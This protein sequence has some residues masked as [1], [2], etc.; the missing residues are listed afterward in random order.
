MIRAANLALRRGATELFRDA[1][2]QIQQGERVG[3]IGNNGCGKSSLFALLMGELSADTGELNVPA[4]WCIAIMQQE[5]PH[6]RRNAVEYVIDGDTELRELEAKL[7]QAQK[8]G[9]DH[10]AADLLGELDTIQAYNA[11]TRANQLLTG[12]GFKTAHL[13]REVS[14]FSG[15]WRVRLNLARALMRRSNLLLL[16]E[17]TN[18]LDVDAVAWLESW[19]L[20]YPGTLLLISHDRDF[21][22]NITQRTLRFEQGC[23]QVYQG[24]YSAAEKQQA[25]RL[26]QQQALYKKQQAR[27]RQIDQFVSRFR[28]KAS[29][30]KQAQSRLKELDRLEII[31]AAHLESPFSFTLPCRE[32]Q[33]DPLLDLRQ[34]DLGYDQTP[35]L[36]GV[37]VS[38]RPGDRIG[39]LG[40]NGAGKT[41]LLKSIAGQI[42]LLSG[43]RTPG[44]YLRIGYFAQQQLEALDL[45]ASPSLQ[46]QRLT[47]QAKE[48][49]IRNFLGGFGFGEQATADSIE[50]FSGGEKA[51]LALAIIAWQQPNLLILDE[52]TNH[53]DMQMRHAL[54]MA[55]QEY[56]GAVLLVSHDRHLLR[57][58]VDEL[59]LVNHGEVNLFDGSLEDYQRQLR[60]HYRTQRDSED[61][62]KPAKPDDN[63]KARRQQAAERR[64]QLQPLTN[65]LKKTEREMDTVNNKL[66]Q[67]DTQIADPELYT[68]SNSDRLQAMLRDQGGLRSQLNELERRWLEQ[69]EALEQAE[70]D[71]G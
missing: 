46:L 30:A 68:G 33:S 23:I 56:P 12:L 50:H 15:G 14:S 2:F 29:K 5:T 10:T 70:K 41:T 22:D 62:S 24:N 51:R 27:I 44:E 19:L 69:Q 9:D 26:L 43:E 7:E 54:T 34:A 6:S 42:A 53:L 8:K 38:I 35:V 52:P 58:T 57:N 13:E 3:V 20:R 61:G 60:E 28:Y 55:L 36:S 65:A 25:E 1:D 64:Q 31:E 37:R 40:P 67:L 32:K 16:D 47:P 49:D 59:L 66:Q 21:L 63:K 48:Q 17:P 71:T 11:E 39:I 18:H 45:Q 4:G